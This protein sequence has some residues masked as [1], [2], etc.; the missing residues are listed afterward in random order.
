MPGFLVRTRRGG[1]APSLCV[2]HNRFDGE[3]ALKHRG[4]WIGLPLA[5]AALVLEVQPAA[6]CTCA[7][8]T[9]IYSDPANEARDVPRN[10][11]ITL[12][13]TLEPSSVHFEDERGNSV[14]FELNAGL[15]HLCRAHEADLLPKRLLAPN[16]RYVVRIGS[17][18]PSSGPASF[19][20]VTGTAVL[21]DP[22]LAPPPRDIVASVRFSGP[23]GHCY[24][25]YDDYTCLDLGGLEDIEIIFRANDEVVFRTTNFIDAG[26]YGTEI[27]PDCVE[28]RRYARRTGKRSEPVRICGADLDPRP[29]GLPRGP[30]PDCVAGRFVVDPA[31][32]WDAGADDGGAAPETD[33]AERDAADASLTPAD[34]EDQHVEACSLTRP[35]SGKGGSS[36]L[37]L[38]A[39][40][41]AL[42]LVLRRSQRQRPVTDSQ[43]TAVR[44]R[45]GKA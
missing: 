36:G 16:T 43:A 32:E 8:D 13:G 25:G 1:V 4:L 41:F 18:H 39:V 28:V 27:A 45:T 26:L 22:E 30:W 17:G 40:T 24:S 3:A 20:F 15:T 44:K 42:A 14:E 33:P 29:W 21:P 37:L 2:R 19:S 31:G 12:V 11:A 5:A 7:Y 6:A 34:R 38:V 10:Q 23:P 9:L 35:A